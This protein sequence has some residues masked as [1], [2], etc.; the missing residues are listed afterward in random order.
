MVSYF[1]YFKKIIDS[2]CGFDVC[3]FSQKAEIAFLGIAP[4]YDLFLHTSER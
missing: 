2:H 4:M 3:Y 1:H